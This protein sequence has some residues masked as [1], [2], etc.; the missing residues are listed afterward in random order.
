[1][2]RTLDYDLEEFVVN[3]FYLVVLRVYTEVPE[4]ETLNNQQVLLPNPV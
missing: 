1:M 4:V 3:H 2:L